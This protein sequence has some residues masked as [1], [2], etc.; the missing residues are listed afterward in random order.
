MTASDPACAP[1]VRSRAP[2]GVP[3]P[4]PN[5]VSATMPCRGI[6][7][8]PRVPTLGIHPSKQ[9]RVLKE[10]RIVSVPRTSTPIHLMRCSFRTHL[11]S[12]MRF[13]G[14]APWAGMHCPLQGKLND[15][16]FR[17]CVHALNGRPA[18][19]SWYGLPRWGSCHESGGL[20]DGVAS[21]FSRR[22]PVPTGRALRVG[23]SPS[24][25]GWQDGHQQLVRPAASSRTSGVAH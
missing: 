19:L 12:G 24:G 15:D 8:Q 10:R 17:S 11:F 2:A 7:Y 13:P 25:G 22:W 16:G 14:L 3:I 23:V 4:S 18:S 9:T 6:A 20:A 5:P 1:R 21:G